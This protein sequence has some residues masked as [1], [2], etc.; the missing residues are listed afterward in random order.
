M[1][2]KK[3]QKE[4][5]CSTRVALKIFRNNG[6]IK[7]NVSYKHVPVKGKGSSKSEEGDLCERTRP[8]GTM[9]DPGGGRTGLGK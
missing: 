3:W 5:I 9:I 4:L 1:L 6:R 2:G 8:E 7:N